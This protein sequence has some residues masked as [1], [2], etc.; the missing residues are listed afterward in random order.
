MMLIS[1][2]MPIDEWDRGDVGNEA[3]MYLE[4]ESN[5][6]TS[7][8]QEL[9]EG[10]KAMP[11]YRQN[12]RLCNRTV[13]LFVTGKPKPKKVKYSD[14]VIEPDAVVAD[15]S[16]KRWD[17]TMVIKIRSSKALEMDA[18]DRIA[19]IGKDYEQDMPG[20]DVEAVAKA[21]HEMVACYQYPEPDFSWAR[22]KSLR[23]RKKIEKSERAL[24]REIEALKLEQRNAEWK[25]Q[26]RIKKL[27]EKI[28]KLRGW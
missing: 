10:V 19:H 28:E 20:K 9:L 15:H 1:L 3:T 25:H 23:S 21:I 2:M 11:D 14:E 16:P 4:N 6:R 24:Q 18:L 5:W 13:L 12:W 17:D 8:L 26:D 27:D 7:D 22:L